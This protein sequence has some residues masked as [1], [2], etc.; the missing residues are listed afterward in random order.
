LLKVTNNTNEFKDED[1][2]VVYFTAEW[3]GPC[4]QLKPQYG[5]AAVMNPEMNYYVVDVDKISS[6][7][8]NYYNIKSIPQIFIMDKGEIVKKI[9]SKTAEE[10]VKEIRA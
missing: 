6:D 1:T 9:E 3:C 8:L 4:K 5:R 7:D 2:S 10:I